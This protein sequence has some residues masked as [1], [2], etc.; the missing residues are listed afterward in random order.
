ME[1]TPL[2]VTLGLGFL[3]GVKHAL[4]ADHLVA[5]ATIVGRHRSLWRSSIVGAYWGLGHTASLLGASLA[6]LALKRTIP[7]RGALALELVVGVMLVLLGADLLRRIARGELALHSHEHDGHSHLHVHA[8]PSEPAAHHHAIGKRPFL[9][10]LVHG[11]AG[12]AALTLFV[13]T[14]LP[15]LWAGLFYVAVFGAGTIAGMLVM[16]AVVGLPFALAART[17]S[18]LS[19]RIQGIAA[20]G[21]IGFGLWYSYTV[22]AGGGLFRL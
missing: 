21:S 17:A 15:T 7:A 9:I 8:A 1:K 10:G 3:L 11:L 2:V 16:S 12:S 19:A 13:L 5:V 20:V 14:T 6:V 22:L 18:G 4:E